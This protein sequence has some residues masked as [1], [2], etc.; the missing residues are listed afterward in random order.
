MNAGLVRLHSAARLSIALVLALGATALAAGTASAEGAPADGFSFTAMLIKTPLWVWALLVVLI[1]VSARA[2]QE[3]TVSLVGYV[4]F[5]LI[6]VLFS[7]SALST[8]RMGLT[9]ATA[10]IVGALV[11]IAAGAAL[12]RRF[13]PARLGGGHLRLQGEW[14]TL[15]VIAV[16]FTVRYASN[17]IIAVNKP[18]AATQLFQVSVC[19]VSALMA[20]L[21]GTRMVL[22]LRTAYGAPAADTPPETAG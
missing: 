4:V 9:T 13:A 21:L 19:L 2:T 6:M 16:I 8:T 3:R 22:R 14:T 18:L 17:V 12:E 7:L 11:G 20:A 5:P 1:Y 10:T 15:L